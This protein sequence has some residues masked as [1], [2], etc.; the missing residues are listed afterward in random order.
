D[1]GLEPAQ[2]DAIAALVLRFKVAIEG[3]DCAT[4][5]HGVELSPHQLRTIVHLVTH[6]GQTLSQLAD[7]LGIS[8]GWASRVADELEGIGLVVRQRDAEDRRVVRV[9]LSPKARVVAD[10]IYR[11]RVGAL[12]RVLVELDEGERATVTRF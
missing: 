7:A 11:E 3:L 2:L 1:V 8:L 5:R 4:P 12:S 9:S 6:E 10:A